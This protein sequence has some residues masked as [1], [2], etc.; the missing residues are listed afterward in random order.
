MVAAA[1]AA[2]AAVCEMVT[3]GDER[4]SA[5]AW[6][7]VFVLCFRNGGGASAAVLGSEALVAAGVDLER[8]MGAGVVAA[9]MWSTVLMV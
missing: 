6:L 7:A 2:A 3:A 1:A 4:K 9:G 5:S 8:A